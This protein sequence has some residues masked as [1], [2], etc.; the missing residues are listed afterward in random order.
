VTKYGVGNS[1][2][3]HLS[4]WV[5]DDEEGY[6][7]K[8]KEEVEKLMAGEIDVD[9]IHAVEK[10][11]EEVSPVTDDV[12]KESAEEVSDED[13]KDGKEDDDEEDESEEEDVEEDEEVVEKKLEQKKKKAADEAKDLSKLMMSKKAKRLYG[14][15]QYGLSEKRAKSDVL[16]QKR[17]EIEH[18]KKPDKK[19]GKSV[20]KQ[21]VEALKE[22]RK[23]IG[24]IYDKAGGSMKN[25]K[26]K[27]VSE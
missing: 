22:K 15:M 14:R 17:K 24:K 25:K 18:S 21:K 27:G 23:E 3:P 11:T 9:D 5:D 19:T 26:R 12:E 13:V 6:K 1:L 16:L 8:Y 20:T 7:P 10:E 2:P 4:P